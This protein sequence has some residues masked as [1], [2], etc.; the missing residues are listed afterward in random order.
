MSPGTR[1][2]LFLTL[3]AAGAA[4][5]A[6]YVLSDLVTLAELKQRREDL[7]ALIAERPVAFT[8]LYFLAFA[9]VAAFSPGTSLFKVAAGAVFGLAAGFPLALAASLSAAVIG[10]VTSRYLVR[11]WAERR[12]EKR[13]EVVNRGVAQ[14]G[15]VFLLA[16]RFNPLVPF[17]LINFVAGLTP[18]RL[19]V[20]ALTSLFGLIPA[21]FVYTNAGTELARIT[22]TS[23]LLSLRLLGSLLLLSLMPL[24]G[25]WAAKA[26]RRRRDAIAELTGKG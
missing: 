4:A 16:L 6:L 11:G 26:L 9:L 24:A 7:L 15:V 19:W 8:S 22:S 3:L 12:F 25:R 21:T 10:F 5:L 1:R 20:F 2:T 17:I 14:E 13:V 23:D 18:M